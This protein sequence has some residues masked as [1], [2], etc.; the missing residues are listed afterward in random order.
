MSVLHIDK[1]LWTD[2]VNTILDERHHATQRWAEHENHPCS[3]YAD[4][5]RYLNEL[6]ERI[7]KVKP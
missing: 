6:V 4:D 3:R 5:V 1:Q 7:D 2:V